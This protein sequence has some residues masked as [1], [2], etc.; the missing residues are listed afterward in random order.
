MPKR[1]SPKPSPRRNSKPTPSRQVKDERWQQQ[2]WIELFSE[3]TFK[4]RQSLQLKEILRAT[5]T[6]VQRILQADRVLIYQ[7]FADGTGKAISEAVLPDYTAILDL[8]FP[9]EVFPEDYQKLYSEGRVRR[10]PMSM[11]HLRA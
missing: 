1:S 10:S 4:I 8:E 7:V 2:Q 6:E 3:V 5:V 9:E 11:I